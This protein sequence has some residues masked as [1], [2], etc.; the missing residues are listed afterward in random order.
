[1]AS[2]LITGRDLYKRDSTG[3]VR[4][5]RM[6]RQGNQ[7]R[8]IARLKDGALTTSGWTDCVGKQGRTDE[9]QAEFEMNAGYE[10]QLKREYFETE[11]EIDKPRF[12]KPMLAQKWS[13]LGWQKAVSKAQGGRVFI[14]PKLDG[15]CCIAQASGMTSREGQPIVSAPHIMAALAPFFRAFPDAVFHGELYNHDLHDDFQTLSS[16]L[17]KQKPTDADLARSAE[18]VQFHIYDYPSLGE[19]VFAERSNMLLQDLTNERLG[20]CIRYVETHE[21]RGEDELKLHSERYL[22][23]G[24]EGSIIRLN[25]PYEQKRSWSVLKHKVFEDGEFEIVEIRDGVGNFAGLPKSV[26]VRLE[27]GKLSDAGVKGKKDFLESLRAKNPKTVTVR[28]FGRTKD[29]KLRMGVAVDWHGPE[30]RKL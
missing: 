12:F 2:E 19:M 21:V 11:A 8:T 7:H 5:W 28:Y 10:H 13:D 29:G 14:Q 4:V 22:D 30:G 16:V 24:Y 23:Q 17:K 3:K 9:Q 25:L 18:L 15:F 26:T 20:D 6:E 27:N 1:M